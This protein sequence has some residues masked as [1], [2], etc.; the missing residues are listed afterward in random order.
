M[1]RNKLLRSI[2]KVDEVL[3]R[4]EIRSLMDS[5][6]RPLVLQ[7][8]R[9]ALDSARKYIIQ[10][11]EDKLENYNI[12][13]DCIIKSSIRI[14]EEKH[15]PNLKKVINASGIIIHTNL[16]RSLLCDDAV[17]AVS[18]AAKNYTNLEYDIQNGTRGSRYSHI[19]DLVVKITGAESAM[20]VNNNAGAVLLA[21]STLCRGKEAI[22]SRGELVEVGGSFRIPEVME[23]SGAMLREVGATNK[24][25]FYDY[26][27]AVNENTG[28]ILKVHTS[29]YRILGFTETVGGKELA[30][31][32]AKTGIPVVEDLG[33]GS[34][35]DFSK[36]G[37]EYEP[38]VQ[39]E[40][41]S[42]IDLVTFSGD[43]MLG[44][45]QAGIIA[46]K[47]KY[48]DLIKMNP[49]TRALRIDKMT[50]AALEATL[51]QYIDEDTAI[52]NIPT[53]RMITASEDTIKQKAEKLGLM[54][55]KAAGEN[56]KIK[57]ERDYSQIGGGS[58]P[59]EN[60]PTYV[61]SL[62]SLSASPS[63]I[64]SRLRGY[65]VPIIARVCRDRVLFDVRTVEDCDLS[66]IRDAVIS[67]L[68]EV[69]L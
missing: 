3:G 18:E 41:K 63:E 25:H 44:G 56:V 51:R 49:L 62:R 12:D 64:E 2:P 37:L 28:V 45:P 20:A 7:S 50:L 11:P 4:Y 47:K 13:I 33:S 42:G 55:K 69:N 22:V 53:L 60:L 30:A 66:I 17:K 16:G 32:G 10:N 1:D 24:T 8:V 5:L 34:F 58:M 40:I 46:G 29:N 15:T 19:E 14:A 61:V 26:E 35:V 39:D 27:K 48:L 67:I 9:E 68:G 31:L 65:R 43:K 38:T 21:L 36:Y 54:M 59:L 23:Q 52:E 6:P 57:V